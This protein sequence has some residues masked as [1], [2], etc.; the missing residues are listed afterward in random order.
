MC[1]ILKGRSGRRYAGK[2]KE[3]FL[4]YKEEMELVEMK[5]DNRWKKR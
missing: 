3:G 4:L 2:K 5:E 1:N